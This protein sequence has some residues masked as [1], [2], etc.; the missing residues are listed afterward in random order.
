[1]VLTLIKQIAFQLIPELQN[2]RIYGVF[3]NE[4]YQKHNISRLCH[5][6]TLKLDLK[7]KKVLELGAGVGEH[8]LFYLHKGCDVLPVDGR[9]ELVSFIKKRLGIHAEVLNLENELEKLEKL[10]RFDLIHC[11]GLLYHLS[12]P[13]ELIC[14]CSKIADCILI[15]TCVSRGQDFSINLVDEDSKVASQAITGK[16]CRPTRRWVFETL[17]KYF[18]YVYCPKTQPHDPQF[19]VIWDDETNIDTEPSLIRAIFVASHKPIYSDMLLNYVPDKYE[20]W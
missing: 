2:L 5:L 3:F 12:N 4:K 20:N 7:N 10:G 1:M 9:P 16:G 17:R 13:E 15:S 11:Y 19:P 8:T 18:E 6:D 14:S